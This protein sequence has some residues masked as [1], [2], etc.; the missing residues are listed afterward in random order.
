MILAVGFQ[1]LILVEGYCCSRRTDIFLSDF[2]ASLTMGRCKKMDSYNFLLE[3]IWLLEGQFCQFS[4]SGKCLILIF[5]PEFLSRCPVG[6]QLQWLVTWFLL[7]W[8]VGNILYF[9][10]PSLSVLISIKVWEAFVTSLSHGTWNAHS[11]ARQGFCWKAY[12][13]AIT[14]FGPVNRSSKPLDCQA[15]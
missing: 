9:I 10:I 5:C 12:Q 2:S 8:M 7:H 13:W 4:Q 6:Q 14:A 3:N 11:Q 15:Y 1:A